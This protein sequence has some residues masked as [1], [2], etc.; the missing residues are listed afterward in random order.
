MDFPQD[1]FFDVFLHRSH[2][3][4]MVLP[5]R[6]DR[7]QLFFWN[8]SSWQKVMSFDHGSYGQGLVSILR[9]CA[10]MYWWVQNCR[11]HCP[12]LAG[13]AAK[14]LVRAKLPGIKGAVNEPC[15][16]HH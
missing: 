16:K 8:P 2:D 4:R 1:E 13:L 7:H 9:K 3:Q 14:Q 10:E 6:G 11:C 15:E 12:A 5:V